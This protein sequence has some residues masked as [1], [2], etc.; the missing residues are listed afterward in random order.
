MSIRY[1]LFNIP[2]TLE[3]FVD[4]S[5]K[6]GEASANITIY[7]F[8]IDHY[9]LGNGGYKAIAEAGRVNWKIHKEPEVFLS[10]P[11]AYQ[12]TLEKAI[13]AAEEL[14]KLGIPTTI[15]GKQPDALYTSLSSSQLGSRQLIERNARKHA[16]TDYISN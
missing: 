8:P 14:T 10:K 15:M 1:K 2:A 13:I 7:S 3:E 12:I 6:K 4:K 9:E 16:H 5:R 11:T